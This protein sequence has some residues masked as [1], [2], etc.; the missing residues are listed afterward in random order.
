MP[1]SLWAHGD[2]GE[3]D[4]QF[5]SNKLQV[6]ASITGQIVKTAHRGEILFPAWKGAVDG[7]GPA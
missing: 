5:L 1:V 2:R 7:L 3:G 6:T 4:A